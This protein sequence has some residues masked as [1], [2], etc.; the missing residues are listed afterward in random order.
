MVY[1][2]RDNG[3]ITVGEDGKVPVTYYGRGGKSGKFYP[4]KNGNILLVI[5]GDYYTI[6]WADFI[7][8][9]LIPISQASA[10]SMLEEFFSGL[11][12]QIS[13]AYLSPILLFDFYQ[14]LQYADGNTSIIDLSNNANNGTPTAGNGVG[15][16]ESI[17]NDGVQYNASAR[18]M[19]FSANSG[20]QH[21]IR[22]PDY[23][24]FEGTTN[25]TITLWFKRS[26]IP[27][28]G[29]YQG[30]VGC[31][32]YGDVAYLGMITTFNNIGGN[33]SMFHSRIDGDGYEGD[34]ITTEFGSDPINPF[35]TDEWYM[36]S[37]GYDGSNIYTILYQPSGNRID[38]SATA[39]AVV[40]ADPNWSAFLG[41]RLNN[42]LNGT[43]FGVLAIHD[44]W[45]GT[46]NTDIIYNSTKNRYGY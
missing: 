9:N 34:N 7:I 11:P 35:Y 36:V 23:F 1:L 28:P 2:Y 5:G 13:T 19:D 30:L 8:E 38:A 43:S 41:L 16:P 42:W 40:L 24:K 25:Y 46:E 18:T 12:V 33:L 6:N 45:I 39:S 17:N 26:S 14:N 10:I 37:F 27:T 32:G 22:L 20:A 15:Y 44:T 21:E 31:Q 4:V 29:N 3:V